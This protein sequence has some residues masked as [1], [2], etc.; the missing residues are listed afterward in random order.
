[1]NI[2]GMFGFY[3]FVWVFVGNSEKDR[4]GLGNVVRWYLVILGVMVWFIYI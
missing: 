4:F 1:M 3:W 2:L